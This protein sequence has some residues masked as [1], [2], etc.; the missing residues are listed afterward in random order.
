MREKT[1]LTT[2][3]KNIMIAALIAVLHLSIQPAMAQVNPEIAKCGELQSEGAKF[4]MELCSAHLGCRMVLAFHNTCAKA[5]KFV[6]NLTNAVGKGIKTF[7]G[8]RKEVTSDHVFEA[9]LSDR[10]RAVEKDVSWN[11]KIQPI[12][13]AVKQV[14]ENVKAHGDA[15]VSVGDLSDAG[16]IKGN[17]YDFLKAGDSLYISRKVDYGI[18]GGIGNEYVGAKS[19]TIELQSDT[20]V[21]ASHSGFGEK[22]A[23][24]LFGNGEEY[25][26]DMRIVR[27]SDTPHG[28]GVKILTNGQRYVGTF[29]EGKMTEGSVLRRDGTVSAKGQ[30]DSDGN[31]Y[32]GQLFDGSGTVVTQNIDKPGDHAK[33]KAAAKA[34]AEQDYRDSLNAMNAGQLFAKADELSSSGD[35]QKAREVL[36]TL[37]SRFPDHALAAAAAQR[38]S[39]G[40]AP[41]DSSGKS[42]ATVTGTMSCDDYLNSLGSIMTKFGANPNPSTQQERELAMYNVTTQLEWGARN[43][44]CQSTMPAFRNKA[45]AY[46]AS[47]NGARPI[48]HGVNTGALNAELER[49]LAAATGQGGSQSMG[50]G[51]CDARVA[52]QEREFEA[53]NRRPVP[54]GGTPPLRRVMWMTS[55]RIKLLRTHCPSTGKYQQMINELQTAYDQSKRACEQMMA[56]NVCPGPNAY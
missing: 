4:Q 38:L 23:N 53:V 14:K 8:Y 20:R 17:G 7:F 27:G 2:M 49:N 28:S 52:A 9:S 26:G 50:D 51:S 29:V 3:M 35:S 56:G 15:L 24:V 19:D 13:S 6:N 25:R 45:S 43:P 37:V 31:L 42:A 36:R 44:K 30:W 39:M 16:F 22:Q 54:E 18:R 12:Q 41:S 34:K 40:G 1:V 48:P 32:V 5:E 55:E 33:A 11:E 46:M 10:Q 47:L 21:V